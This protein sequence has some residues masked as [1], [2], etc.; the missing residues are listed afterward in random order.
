M[1]RITYAEECLKGSSYSKAAIKSLLGPCVISIIYL[2]FVLLFYSI[3]FV[4]ALTSENEQNSDDLIVNLMAFG[5]PLVID[6]IVAS[7]P[8][9]VL[10]IIALTTASND[11]KRQI[12]LDAMPAKIQ[13]FVDINGYASTQEFISYCMNS[14]D[15]ES[16]AS[17]DDEV[18]SIP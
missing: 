4:G 18:R 12:E 3:F 14:P 8:F 16:S 17:S 7:A 11:K 15:F 10:A 2:F 1:S 9:I 5:I 6:I 13:R